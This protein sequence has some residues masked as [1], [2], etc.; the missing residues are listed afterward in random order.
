MNGTLFWAAGSIDA[1]QRRLPGWDQLDVIL[2]PSPMEHD[3][4]APAQFIDGGEYLVPTQFGKEGDDL[5]QG[6]RLAHM[7]Q[8][9]NQRLAAEGE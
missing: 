2:E 4:S 1:G 8:I 9:E 5:L 7:Q 6:Q 3:L